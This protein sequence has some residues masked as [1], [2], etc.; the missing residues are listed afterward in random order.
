M[1]QSDFFAQP[2]PDSHEA[3]WPLQLDV[4]RHVANVQYQHEPGADVDGVSVRVPLLELPDLDC[5]RL[6]WLVPGLIA[7]KI[8]ALI[9]SLPK[10]VRARFHP[11]EAVIQAF[12]E[13]YAVGSGSL[14]ELLARELKRASGLEVRVEDFAL[15]NVPAH[16]SA[17]IEVIDNDGRVLASSRDAPEL[18]RRFGAQAD[19]ARRAVIARTTNGLPI[20][21]EFAWWIAPLP[22]VLPMTVN[23]SHDAAQV[24]AWAALEVCQTGQNRGGVR[25]R[26]FA[27]LQEAHESQLHALCELVLQ[28]N[29]GAIEHHLEFH[30]AYAAIEFVARLSGD[31]WQN[32]LLSRIAE[33]ILLE[34]KETLPTRQEFNEQIEGVDKKILGATQRVLHAVA[35]LAEQVRALDSELKRS[36]PASWAQILQ[37]AKID[38]DD[39]LRQDWIQRIP[40]NYLLVASTLI[41][42]H[43]ARVVQLEGAGVLRAQRDQF[44]LLWKPRL[45]QERPKRCE[46]KVWTQL[47]WNVRLA[48]MLPWGAGQGLTPPIRER[49]LEALWLGFT[50]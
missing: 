24:R 38:R 30:G 41:K 45:A 36:S 49:D 20:G 40:L 39:L 6:E 21:K 18:L 50:R 31:A 5:E 37:E 34:G 25:L 33:L 16:F 44:D 28:L 29:R 8:E 43:R 7:E 2:L 32:Q 42:A 19:Q 11:V 9:R 14:L 23:I 48:R 26:Q 17:R 1:T 13:Q 3:Q 15:A 35:G 12:L 27:T 46:H 22:E 10:R 4:G 47:Q